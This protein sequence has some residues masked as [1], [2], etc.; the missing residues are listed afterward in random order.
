MLA[1]RPQPSSSQHR[2][3]DLGFEDVDLDSPDA[4][5]SKTRSDQAQPNHQSQVTPI[6]FMQHASQDKAASSQLQTDESDLMDPLR[7]ESPS[8]LSEPNMPYPFAPPVRTPTAAAALPASAVHL[9]THQ[10][11]L[12]HGNDSYE[13]ARGTLKAHHEEALA[14][15]LLEV[16]SASAAGPFSTYS[17]PGS[18]SSSTPASPSAAPLPTQRSSFL[19]RGMSTQLHKAL[20][21][22]AAA[23]SK[24]S[25]AIA[26]PPNTP[27]PPSS[28]Q[29]GVSAKPQQPAMSLPIP[30][31]G[32][33]QEFPFQQPWGPS[34]PASTG[35]QDRKETS[36]P[37][38]QQQL[39][40]LQ[41]NLHSPLQLQADSVSHSNAD[42]E[43]DTAH[44]T[45]S[46]MLNGLVQ[47]Q[48][49]GENGDLPAPGGDP[50]AHGD[51]QAGAVLHRTGF[52]PPP[53]DPGPPPQGSQPEFPH[54]AAQQHS[55]V[56]PDGNNQHRQQLDG[57]RMR[58]LESVG[59]A[60]SMSVSMSQHQQTPPLAA[61]S[62]EG[63]GLHQQAAEW[64]GPASDGLP[65]SGGPGHFQVRSTSSVAIAVQPCYCQIGC[66]VDVPI[67]VEMF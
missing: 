51:Q 29:E 64:Q 22:T 3:H 54:T 57:D 24:A 12:L 35:S 34:G 1:A 9:P 2:L 42:S 48:S 52:A 31:G 17:G 4:S 19:P 21:A 20:K 30:K 43:A 25:A 15:P 10:D 27:L 47:A 63:G 6:P 59:D 8:Q 49:L 53:S 16:P 50:S 40:N 26:P 58:I 45:H 61:S 32:Q 60:D 62:G 28:W 11:Q 37:W 7:T 46:A 38:W 56:S 33:D 36:K 65:V 18:T 66:G 5:V 55:N 23:A 13:T 39:Q 41:Q 44:V 67:P 14:G